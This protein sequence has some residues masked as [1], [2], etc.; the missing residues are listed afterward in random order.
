MSKEQLVQERNGNVLGSSAVHLFLSPAQIFFSVIF[1]FSGM[2]GVQNKY[3]NF[4]TAFC[5]ATNLSSAKLTILPNTFT[6]EVIHL[7]FSSHGTSQMRNLG[8]GC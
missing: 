1:I 8:N 3:E 2:P 7:Y 6:R 4:R 5:T